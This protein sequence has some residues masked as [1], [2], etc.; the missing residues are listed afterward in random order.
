MKELETDIDKYRHSNRNLITQALLNKGIKEG[1]KTERILGCTIDFFKNYISHQL[2]SGQD[3]DMFKSGGGLELDHIIPIGEAQSQEECDILSNYKNIQ[4]LTQNANRVKGSTKDP[5]YD[6]IAKEIGWKCEKNKKKEKIVLYDKDKFL[7]LYPIMP[8][9]SNP[10]WAD[11]CGVEPT[12]ISIWKMENRELLLKKRAEY[13]AE[14]RENIKDLLV[15]GTRDAITE[16]LKILKTS[17]S[18]KNRLQ[19]ASII[20]TFAFPY[21]GN[22]EVRVEGNQNITITITEKGSAPEEI[23]QVEGETIEIEEK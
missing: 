13:L 1:T 2:E 23:K 21:V 19:A 11:S 5:R 20:K 10:E 6:E 15:D 4:V 14:V 12:T 17:P 22:N 3:L 16:T 18:E 9:K 7:E 8:H